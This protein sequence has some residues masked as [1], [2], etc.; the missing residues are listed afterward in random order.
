[1]RGVLIFPQ[2]CKDYWKLPNPAFHCPHFR[3]NIS[4]Y[5]TDICSWDRTGVGLM[6]ERG[7][8]KSVCLHELMLTQCSGE[9]IFSK[10]KYFT[11]MGIT[12]FYIVVWMIFNFNKS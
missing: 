2:Y 10:F 7:E 8:C 9:R 3:Y 1:M 11:L 6:H 5:S 12:N 4:D